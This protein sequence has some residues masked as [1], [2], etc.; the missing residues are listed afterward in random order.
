MYSTRTHNIWVRGM[1]ERMVEV[2][3]LSLA[4]VAEADSEVQG[5]VRLGYIVFLKAS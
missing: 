2:K 4:Y 1:E 3:D 5:R